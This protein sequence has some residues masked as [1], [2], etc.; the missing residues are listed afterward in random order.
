MRKWFAVYYLSLRDYARQLE[1]DRVRWF[2][3]PYW[4]MVVDEDRGVFTW[5]GGNTTQFPLLV[6]SS[7]LD[8]ELRAK[9]YH[10]QRETFM[11]RSA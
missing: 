3:K 2:K 8:L 6:V 5:K 9:M 1:Q 10:A 7:P 11:S 4:G